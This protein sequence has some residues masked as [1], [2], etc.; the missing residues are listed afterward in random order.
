VLQQK[1]LA[2]IWMWCISLW[3]FF[4]CD[5]KHHQLKLRVATKYFAKNL[6]VPFI[7]KNWTYI[8]KKL[9]SIA[10]TVIG[11]LYIFLEFFFPLTSSQ[12]HMLATLMHM[13]HLKQNFAKKQNV[14]IFR[15]YL[16]V[17]FLYQWMKSLN[18]YKI[19]E[20]YCCCWMNK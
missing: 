18:C 8:I 1:K 2:Q 16:K 3:S 13:V 14:F 19:L 20:W 6:K 4:V 17:D 5:I 15:E 11:P 7:F 9:I 12:A 10:T